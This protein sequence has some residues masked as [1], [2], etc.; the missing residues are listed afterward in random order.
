MQINDRFGTPPRDGLALAKS[1]KSDTVSL[2]RK[3]LN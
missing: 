2:L 1:D 3:P